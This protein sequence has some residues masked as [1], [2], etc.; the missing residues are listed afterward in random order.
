LRKSRYHH[1]GDT[2]SFVVINDNWWTRDI[3]IK[4]FLQQQL[5]NFTAVLQQ[6][7][8][9]TTM[10]KTT[11]VLTA[12]A[13]IASLAACSLQPVTEPFV[14]ATDETAEVSMP[15][16]FEVPPAEKPIGSTLDRAWGIYTW[17]DE[18]FEELV[19]GM[20]FGATPTSIVIGRIEDT[21]QREFSWAL[22]C[23]EESRDP[24]RIDVVTDFTLTVHETLLGKEVDSL[25]FA[26]G[27]TTQP[28]IGDTLLLFLWEHPNGSYGLV[29]YEEGIFRINPD[30]TVYSFSNAEFTAQFDG[31]P[32]EA[33][34]SEIKS[35][36]ARVQRGE[37]AEKFTSEY[38]TRIFNPTQLEQIR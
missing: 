1:I 15:E 23:G 5:N 36:L 6:K 32:L 19:Q 3:R 11:S 12:I 30:G 7:R 25:I 28:E 13:L 24:T 16:E 29:Q 2:N 22:E 4:A 20:F 21:T 31:L 33:L 18:T 38:F 9:K 8:R 37:F 27:S 34:T 35:S 26:I 14:E 10:K 17:L